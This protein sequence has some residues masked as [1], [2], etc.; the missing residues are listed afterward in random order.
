MRRYFKVLSTVLLLLLFFPVMVRAQ[1]AENRTQRVVTIPQDKVI[2]QDFFIQAGEI[3]EISG[4]VNGDVVVA[5]GQL[6][7]DGTVNG[8]LLAAGGTINLTGEVTQDVRIAGGQITIGGKVG[9]NLTV[10]GGNVE[11][12]QSSEVGGGLL[13]AGGN[14]MLSGEIPGDVTVFAGNLTIASKIGGNVNA[15]V[16]SMRLTSNASI[17]KDLVYTSEEE[18]MIDNNAS[19]SG[20]MLRKTPP[21][22]M[23]PKELPSVRSIYGNLFRMRVQAAIIGFLSS[24]LVGVILLKLFPS[25]VETIINSLE[26]KVWASLAWGFVLMIFTPIALVVVMITIIGIPLALILFMFYFIFLYLAKIFVSYLIGSRLKKRLNLQSSYLVMGVGLLA[27][28]L[29]ALAPL[30]GGLWAFVV[31]LVGFGASFLAIRKSTFG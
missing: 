18:A 3:V 10:A 28:Y 12:T 30:V 9:R 20:Q 14:I 16:G 8:D 6:L 5:G 4:T 23:T 24:L 13:V 22:G 2:D 19:I 29:L 11:V 21:E 26:K 1:G 25:F 31:T 7:V 27:Y 17:E 15:Y